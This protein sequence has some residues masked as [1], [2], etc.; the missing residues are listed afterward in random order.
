MF[1]D[2]YQKHKRLIILGGLA[3]VVALVAWGIIYNVVLFHVTSVSP[4]PNNASYLSPRLVVTFNKDLAADGVAVTLDNNALK[5]AV[6]RNKLTI[7]LPG[8]FEG[9]KTYNIDIN[10]VN[11]RA[12]D[13]IKDHIIQM[14]TVLSSDSLT[15]EDQQLIL[16]QQEANKSPVIN[17]PIFNYLPHSTLDY[18]MDAVINN[19]DT[20]LQ[21]L[22]IEIKLLLTAA[23]VKIDRNAAIA[24]YK[25][26]AMDYLSSL[27]G[28]DISKYNVEVTVN[29]PT[30]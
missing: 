15:A 30:L 17:D 13:V 21:S 29:D 2:M 9:N 14:H 27:K 6:D 23:D 3:L 26:E 10:S 18:S 4:N 20:S 1:V 25:Q 16:D 28:I 19:A 8:N 22:T 24:Q 12:G 7:T 11:S 5:T